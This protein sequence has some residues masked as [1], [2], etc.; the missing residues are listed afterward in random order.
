VLEDGVNM[1]DHQ[2]KKKLKRT[3]QENYFEAPIS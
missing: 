1:Y 3:P 2:F